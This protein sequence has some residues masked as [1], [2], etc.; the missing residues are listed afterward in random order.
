MAVEGSPNYFD[1]A[2]TVAAAFLIAAGASVILGAFLDWVS[3][4]PPEVVPASEAPKVEPFSGV[5]TTDGWIVIVSGAI[6]IVCG[7]I[8]GVRRSSISALVA[9]GTAVVIGAVGIADYR[10]IDDL[11]Y[12]EMN[13]VGEPVPAVGI[14]LVV[15]GAIV[16][17]LSA[18]MAMA[19][20]PRRL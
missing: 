2:R 9:F 16:G 18:A 5:E 19:A 6:L 7:I 10:G 12:R 11:F 17:L 4:T 15:G 14:M 13:R 1:K 8:T 3:V 20:S